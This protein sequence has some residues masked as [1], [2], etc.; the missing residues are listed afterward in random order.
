LEK[1]RKIA[2]DWVKRQIEER[3]EEYRDKIRKTA[4][5]SYYKNREKMRPIQNERHRLYRLNHPEYLVKQRE[6]RK[7]NPEKFKN[8]Y[9]KRKEKQR[10][11]ARERLLK[12]YGLN[13][14]TFNH[15]FTL[16]E[17]KCAICRIPFNG[18]TPKIDHNHKTGKTRS[19][20][21]QE[22]TFVL[23]YADKMLD[24][25]ISILEEF[26]KYL[27]THNCWGKH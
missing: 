12:K 16:Q 24:K 22:C 25:N 27:K 7:N 18:N 6:Y 4:L 19:L 17:G 23:G 14:E 9:M 21:C 5:R 10:L 20:L 3:G 15:L 11:W 13:S 8:Y 1:A 26:A 2:R